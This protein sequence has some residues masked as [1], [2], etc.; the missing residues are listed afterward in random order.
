LIYG[1]I[2]ANEEENLINEYLDNYELSNRQIILYGRNATDSSVDK[3]YYQL[4]SLG[5][6]RVFIYRGGLFEWLLLQDIYGFSAFPTTKKILD[7]LK[8]K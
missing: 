5:C 4:I 8:Y 7:I 2:P 6:K 3:K 1:T